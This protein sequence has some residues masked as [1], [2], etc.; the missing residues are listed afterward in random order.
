MPRFTN[1]VDICWHTDLLSCNTIGSVLFASEDWIRLVDTRTHL[2]SL[3]FLFTKKHFKQMR[4]FYL[5]HPLLAGTTQDWSGENHRWSSPFSALKRLVLYWR[6]PE[7]RMTMNMLRTG[8]RQQS[9]RIML[10]IYDMGESKWDITPLLPRV[11]L[12]HPWAEFACWGWTQSFGG[13]PIKSNKCLKNR[14]L[15]YFKL[16]FLHNFENP[17]KPSQEKHIGAGTATTPTAP[18]HMHWLP[19]CWR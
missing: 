6:Y 11:H 4:T 8:N 10:L 14:I 17:H 7:S 16:H 2:R 1:F 5:L 15:A 13:M 9:I 12:G 19:H 18:S 3:W